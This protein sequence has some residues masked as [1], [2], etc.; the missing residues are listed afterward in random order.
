MS[1][2]LIKIK[3]VWSLKMKILFE[4]LAIVLFNLIL[5]GKLF[6]FTKKKAVFVDKYVVFITFILLGYCL[7]AFSMV[8]YGDLM[9]KLFFL[10][11][12][13]SPFLIGKLITY[14]TINFYTYLQLSLFLFSGLYAVYFLN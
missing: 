14:K 8:F 2:K 1:L 6:I 7:C 9:N 4:V 3:L 10:F 5:I 12:G 11:F 13:F